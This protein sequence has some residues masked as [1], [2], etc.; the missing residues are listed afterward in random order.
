MEGGAPR[1]QRVPKRRYLLETPQLPGTPATHSCGQPAWTPCGG[2]LVFVAWP[3]APGNFPT[4]QRRLG[5]VFCYNRPCALYYVPVTC[6]GA[7]GGGAGGG[8]EGGGEGGDEGGDEGAAAIKLSG[9]LLSAF[10]P[11]FAPNGGLLVF[12]SQDAAARSGVHS[13]TC[14]LHTLRWA[15][16]DGAAAAAAAAGPRTVVP[17]VRRPQ[18]PDAFPGLYPAAGFPDCPFLDD[19]TVVLNSQWYSQG[20]GLAVSLESGSVTP[21]TPVG[22]EHGSWALQVQQRSATPALCKP[23]YLALQYSHSL[24]ERMLYPQTPPRACAAA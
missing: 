19:R 6:V 9:S 10:A 23:A 7:A 21:L 20:V 16:G 22:P 15:C 1:A 8:D 3:H 11:V 17:V 14:S 4:T 24:P 18:A 5:I 13:G 2:G 12:L